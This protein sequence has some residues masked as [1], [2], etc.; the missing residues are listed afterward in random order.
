MNIK[1]DE[2]IE[3]YEMG[4][5]IFQEYVSEQISKELKNKFVYYQ[6]HIGIKDKE[7]WDFSEYAEIELKREYEMVIKK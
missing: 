3:N 7:N 1:F 4:N 6:K 5:E 2:L